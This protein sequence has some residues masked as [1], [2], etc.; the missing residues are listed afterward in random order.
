MRR[1]AAVLVVLSTPGFHAWAQERDRSLERVGLAL[2]QPPPILRD[3]VAADALRVSTREALGVSI[4]E[5]LPGGVKLGPFT[6]GTTHVR[7]E[8][9]RLSLPVGEYV[10]RGARHLSAANRRRKERAAQRQVA[11]DL[12]AFERHRTQHR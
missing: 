8:I 6:L 3:A 12:E 9:I 2:E 11:A 5:P 4:F 7:G 1:L 10:S